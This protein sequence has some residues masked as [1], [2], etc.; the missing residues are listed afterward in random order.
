MV[1][2]PVDVKSGVIHRGKPRSKYVFEFN[3]DGNTVKQTEIAIPDSGSESATQT[4]FSFNDRGQRVFARHPG[5]TKA[6][7][8]C[9]Y[10]DEGNLKET[11]FFDETTGILLTKTE[12]IRKDSVVSENEYV[13]N[14][15]LVGKT[16][17]KQNGDLVSDVKRY[18]AN[19]KLVSQSIFSYNANGKLVK[20]IN[21]ES[22]R[23][24]ETTCKYSNFD[25][26]GNYLMSTN[27]YNGTPFEIEER[28][29]EYY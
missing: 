7:L 28:L 24:S 1:F 20:T 17:S 25:S 5:K 13:S 4:I 26:T 29:V 8:K 3:L 9:I 27:Y 15:K 16:I 6:F 2:Y 21:V 18:G 19:G 10:D 12:L 23:S 14:G 22:G 11:Y